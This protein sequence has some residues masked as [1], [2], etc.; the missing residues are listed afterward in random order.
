MRRWGIS[1][2]SPSA[3]QATKSLKKLNRDLKTTDDVV[4]AEGRNH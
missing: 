1:P 3:S 2:P 4:L